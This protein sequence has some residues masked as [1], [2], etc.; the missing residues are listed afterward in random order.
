LRAGGFFFLKKLNK[1]Q[2]QFFVLC[3]NKIVM[4]NKILNKE[5]EEIKKKLEEAGAKVELK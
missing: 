2:E 4:S 3:S 1:K 5:I